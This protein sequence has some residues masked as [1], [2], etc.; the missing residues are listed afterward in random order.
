MNFLQKTVGCVFCVLIIPLSGKSQIT[1]LHGYPSLSIKKSAKKQTAQSHR[2]ASKTDSKPLC[3]IRHHQRMPIDF[4]GFLV[5]LAS[6]DEPLS[7]SN[8]L[9]SPYGIIHY[10]EVDNGIRKYYLVTQFNT[11]ETLAKYFNDRVRPNTPGAKM[12]RVKKGKFI[13]LDLLK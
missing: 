4:Q 13:E 2:T 6:S 5:E 3:T 10:R 7:R 1:A 8:P 12:I 11:I 9:F